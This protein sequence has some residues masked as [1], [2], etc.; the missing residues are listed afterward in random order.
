MAAAC[1]G[2]IALSASGMA[3]SAGDAR[4]KEGSASMH[5]P[6][7]AN[8]EQSDK[9]MSSTDVSHIAGRVPRPGDRMRAAM[10]SQAP[11]TNERA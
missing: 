1:V 6:G 3:A 8:G 5:K 9:A 7:M 11:L 4:A 2:A 10:R